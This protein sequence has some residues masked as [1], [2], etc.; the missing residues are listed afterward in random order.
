MKERSNSNQSS[1]GE[2]A[3]TGTQ[4]QP[5][6]TTASTAP[7]NNNNDAQNS[8]LSPYNSNNFMAPPIGAIVQ[9]VSC[10]GNTIQ[11]KVMAYDQQTKILALRSNVPNKAG[12]YDFTM[13]NISWCSSLEVKEEPSEPPEPVSSLNTNKIERRKQLNIE[14]KK[15]EISVLG[16]DVTPI[17]QSLYFTI[18]KTLEDVKWDD[19]RIIV[20][21]SVYI[22]PPY[23]VNSCHGKN[24]DNHQAVE[25]VKKIVKKFNEEYSVDQTM[26]K[27][28]AADKPATAAT[29]VQQS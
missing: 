8:F 24:G 27:A 23:D 22:E 25:H 20:M 11:G 29:D 17:A 7:V 4:Q 16:S 28:A 3:T 1:G 14:S 5:Q 2:S 10:L 12:H 13:V 18:L 15:K 9:C 6:T 21:N 26:T 19:K